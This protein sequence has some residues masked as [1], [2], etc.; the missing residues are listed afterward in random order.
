MTMNASP[1]RPLILVGVLAAAVVALLSAAGCARPRYVTPAQ[2]MVPGETPEAA[3]QQTG[4]LTEREAERLVA[5]FLAVSAGDVDADEVS[6][7][8]GG[9][10]IVATVRS[11]SGH[12]DRVRMEIAPDKEDLRGVKW[13]NDPPEGEPSLNADEAKMVAQVLFDRWFPDV[14]VNMARDAARLDERTFV[15]TWVARLAPNVF[16][17]DRA[18]T[19]ISAVDG[20]PLSYSQYAAQER[21]AA[22]DIPV[23]ASEA[24]AVAK[25]ALA[26]SPDAGRKIAQTLPVLV[27]SAPQSPDGEPLWL[28]DFVFAQ[29]EGG[30]PAPPRRFAVNGYT[31]EVETDLIEVFSVD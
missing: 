28:I 24:V 25:R 26:S 27:L 22:Q 14:P 31:G 23:K 29:P 13:L 2:P 6:E 16:S 8:E 19:L 12:D 1:A 7:T 30:Q 3:Q 21:P 17:G 15:V 20:S 11:A 5:R 10:A 4:G 9:F 18:V